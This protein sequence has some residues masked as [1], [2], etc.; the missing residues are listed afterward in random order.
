MGLRELEIKGTARYAATINTLKHKNSMLNPPSPNAITPL[1]WL[2]TDADFLAKNGFSKKIS[3]KDKELAAELG[4]SITDQPEKRFVGVYY[5]YSKT[6]CNDGSYSQTL[7]SFFSCGFAL[8]QQVAQRYGSI[9][10]TEEEPHGSYILIHDRR[11]NRWELRGF[12]PG[13]EFLKEENE[14]LTST[15][16]KQ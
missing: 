12:I 9:L 14:A 1:P 4:V 16:P 15:P 3:E 6:T 5:G 11:L 8:I 13:I 2:Q 7:S 10:G